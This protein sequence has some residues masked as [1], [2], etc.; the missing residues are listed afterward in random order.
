VQILAGYTDGY[1]PAW[2]GR[3]QIG[4]IRTYML[5]AFEYGAPSRHRHRS[6][7][8]PFDLFLT[9]DENIREVIALPENGRG[10]DPLMNA[11]AA[12]EPFQL[13]SLG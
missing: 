9:D 1:S 10:I 11:P 7:S 5:N 13:E 8:G 4:R 3:A 6:R 2:P 12:V